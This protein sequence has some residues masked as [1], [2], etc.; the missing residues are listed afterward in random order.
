MCQR[1]KKGKLPTGK[2]E[3]AP[4]ADTISPIIS[5]AP[6]RYFFSNVINLLLD[7]V[8][9]FTSEIGRVMTLV[10]A[11]IGTHRESLKYTGI[12]KLKEVIQ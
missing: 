6:C 8:I 9:L 7:E 5:L 12:V 10:M 11:F 2:I 1:K 4:K 3:G